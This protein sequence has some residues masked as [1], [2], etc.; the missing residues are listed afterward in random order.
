MAKE[1]K[2]KLTNETQAAPAAE[3]TA[4]PETGPAAKDSVVDAVFD[5]LT[6][7]ATKGL[8]AAKRGLE[9]SARWLDA[10]AK[11]AGDLATKLAP[12]DQTPGQP[13]A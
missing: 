4:A 7:W 2:A 5:A 12:K 1:K 6:G 10:Q 13:S 8:A 3:T 11:R 9:A